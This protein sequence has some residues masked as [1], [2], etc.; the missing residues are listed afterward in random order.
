MGTQLHHLDPVKIASSWLAEFDAAASLGNAKATTALFL[1]IGWLRDLLVFSWTHRS[2]HGHENITA[3]LADSLPKAQIRDIKL[4]LKHDISPRIVPLP[5]PMVEAAFVFDTPTFHGRGF[6]RLMEADGGEWKALSVF[7]M[8]DDLKGYEEKGPESGY[9][10]RYSKTWAEVQQEMTARTEKNLRVLIGNST[11]MFNHLRSLHRTL[12]GAGQSGLNVGAR[13]RQMDIPAL[14][15][16]KSNNIG[17]TW[18]QRYPS[19]TLHTPNVHH[20]CEIQHIN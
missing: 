1:E 16:D 8:A 9:Y 7:V 14:L 17:D 12:V 3:F 13:F 5:D 18:R 2:I 6:I 4:D 10:E 19:V 11:I 20:S 15:I